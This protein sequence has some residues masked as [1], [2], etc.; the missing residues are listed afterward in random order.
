MTG[1]NPEQL[2]EQ[3]EKAVAA[4]EDDRRAEDRPREPGIAHDALGLALGAQVDAGTGRV[5][6]ERAHV[7]QPVDALAPARRH[8]LAR[9]LDVGLL[10]ARARRSPR[11]ARRPD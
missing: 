4:A 9:E 1:T 11:A 5:R 7:Q 8:D 10:E 3:V 6:I 2:C